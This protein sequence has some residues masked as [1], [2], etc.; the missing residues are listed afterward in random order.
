[1]STSES[2]SAVVMELAEEF[3]DRY[4]QGQRP[5]LREYEDR[6]PELAGEI[7]EVFP[8]M[9]MLENI[10][11]REDSLHGDPTAAPET[12]ARKASLPEQIGDFRI[13]R[14]VG[15]GGMG[16]VYEA[17]QIS[18]GRHVALKILPAQMVR[19]RKQHLRFERE[20]KAAAKL[21]HTN[22]VPV[23]GVGEH[24]GTAYYAMQYIQGLGLDV[25][26]E[27]LKRMRP[28]GPGGSSHGP[29]PALR[30]TPRDI[31]AAD[32]ARSLLTGWFK[33]AGHPDV[34]SNGPP[35]VEA[36][37]DSTLEP[38]SR[39]P[40]GSASSVA[41]PGTGA[42]SGSSRGRP[43]TYWQSVARIGLQVAEALEYAHR[44]GILH[45]DIK[46]SNLLLDTQGTVWV[47][48]FGLAKADDQQNLTH[49]GDIL[50]TIRY[51]PPEAFEGKSDARG[52]VYSLGLTLYELLAFRA[53]FDQQE[54]GK[55]VSQVM[56]EEPARL[57]Q[58]NRE[59]PRDLI[60]IVQ[61]A[62]AREPAH[63]Y[64]TAGA[65]AADLQRF[66]DDEPIQA[67]RVSSLERLARWRRRNKGLAAALAITAF[68]LIW[69]TV[70]SGVMAIR[71]SRYAD[72]AE[73]AA[74]DATAAAIAGQAESARL[75]AARGI[76]LIQQQDGGRG[77]LW[78]V[79]ALELDPTDASGV[80]HAVRVNMA[81]VA[82][83]QLSMRRLTLTPEGASP[84]LAGEESAESVH[85]V[86]Y[87]PDGKIIATAH[88]N[89]HV[90][91]WSAADGRILTPPI[92]C[93]SHI[94]ALAFSRDGRRLWVGTR[95]GYLWS[96]SYYCGPDGE[97]PGQESHAKGGGSS[98][99][100]HEPPRGET[101]AYDAATGR[102]LGAERSG[103]I[104]AGLRSFDRTVARWPSILR[105][106]RPWSTTS[107]PARLFAHRW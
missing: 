61:K 46:P 96:S 21:H 51:M 78:L 91:L 22:I 105:A 104:R 75:A 36:T 19:D 95:R 33:A 3:L 35:T 89:R 74:K 106:T 101:I 58:L 27:E 76:S 2:R 77:L 37:D 55:L 98:P 67:R 52:D 62:I 44:Q 97:I 70:A 38:A 10:A 90:R 82:R 18:L 87:S 107:T 54:R 4:R 69:G 24:E 49:T 48:D 86:A 63:R 11:I 1:M 43:A 29:R 71:T 99:S 53:A 45:R 68:A 80:H 81:T 20:A 9:A 59:I 5:S 102:A 65:L 73:Q 12:P 26:V 47:T 94:S 31:S 41:L 7:R 92:V 6:H 64:A 85:H 79:R 88:K 39:T 103:A 17:E 15:H 66:L 100:P 50:G 72:K 32:V 83:E 14:E 13:I 8:A 56:H 28:G 23:F 25:V 16:V 84:G 30:G 40:S 60:T 34:Q 42:G 57:G 93:D